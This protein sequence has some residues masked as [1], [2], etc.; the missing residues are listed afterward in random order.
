MSDLFAERSER[1][2]VCYCKC[3]KN[4][5]TAKVSVFFFCLRCSGVWGLES[6]V[7]GIYVKLDGVFVNAVPFNSLPFLCV[8]KE[9][10]KGGCAVYCYEPH[11]VGTLEYEYCSTISEFSIRLSPSFV[12][13]ERRGG[14]G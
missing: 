10:R 6:A 11:Y 7:W 14:E 13:G 2:W 5:S 1:V 4:A 12:P 8:K 9:E 3:R